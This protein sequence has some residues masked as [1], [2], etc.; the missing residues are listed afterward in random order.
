M[1]QCAAWPPCVRGAGSAV[2]D[3]L[4]LSCHP[5]RTLV[6]EGPAFCAV[7]EGTRNFIHNAPALRRLR[8]A[9]VLGYH[10]GRPPG[11]VHRS[12]PCI[13]PSSTQ[14]QAALLTNTNYS[15]T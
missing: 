12:T 5:E 9:S 15:A 1:R 4:L 2:L 6:H 3:A 8:R 14:S 11:S 10:A 7:P 13:A